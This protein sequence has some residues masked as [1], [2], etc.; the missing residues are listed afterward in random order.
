MNIFIPDSFSTFNQVIVEVAEFLLG[1]PHSKNTSVEKVVNDVKSIFSTVASDTELAY[2]RRQLDIATERG[3][4]RLIGMRSM[5]L[6]IQGGEEEEDGIKCSVP[7]ESALASLPR[8]LKPLSRPSGAGD[9]A[10]ALSLTGCANGVQHCIFS[11]M[12][13]IF[14]VLDAILDKDAVREQSTSLMYCILA[15][16]FTGV[17]KSNK[18][19]STAIS[20]LRSILSRHTWAKRDFVD[21]DISAADRLVNMAH[22]QDKLRLLKVSSSMLLS[23]S[24]QCNTLEARSSMLDLLLDEITRMCSTL[25]EEEKS[26]FKKKGVETLNSDAELLKTTTANA[27][28]R[29]KRSVKDIM[30]MDCMEYLST[31]GSVFSKSTAPPREQHE[32]YISSLLDAIQAIVGMAE[33][34]D[35]VSKRSH[36]MLSLLG[37]SDQ[38]SGDSSDFLCL[39][40]KFQ[41]RMMRLL[42]PVLLSMDANAI[43]ARKVLVMCQAIWTEHINMNL[44]ESAVALL[45]YLFTFSSDWRASINECLQSGATSASEDPTIFRGVLAYFGGLPQTLADDAFVVIEGE[46]SSSSSSG[47][48]NKLRGGSPSGLPTGAVST[49]NPVED[50]ISGLSRHDALSGVVSGIDTRTGSCDVMVLGDRSSVQIGPRVD[51]SREQH[52]KVTIRA[53]RVGAGNLSAVNELPLTM[54][55]VC[56]LGVV[57]P[58]LNTMKL[59]TSCIKEDAR[60]ELVDDVELKV[61]DLSVTDLMTCGMGLR[62]VS[63]AISDPRNLAR[64]LTEEEASTPYFANAL[65]LG[66]AGLRCCDGLD[67]LS[68]FEA[69]LW[70]VISTRK[71]VKTRLVNLSSAS[72]SELELFAGNE[73]D[74]R[75]QEDAREITAPKKILKASSRAKPSSILMGRALRLREAS[76][77]ANRE[78]DETDE[79]TSAAGRSSSGRGERLGAAAAHLREAAL[80]QMA[81]LGLPRQWAELALDRVGG[82]N[83]EQAVHFCLERSS[84]MESLVAEEAERSSSSSSSLSRRS[85]TFGVSRMASANLLRQLTEM[86]FPRV[87]VVQNSDVND[88]YPSS[89]T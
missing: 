8:M 41:R 36:R 43:V 71:E 70:H 77:T 53:M 68:S 49:P 1:F 30:S 45:R 7:I 13:C 25:R 61:M 50:V 80:I 47:T 87:S 86:G 78:Q 21:E 56:G 65:L 81:E 32:I 62:A 18:T 72:E 24:V 17:E 10:Q 16:H 51:A 64:Y 74:A 28:G 37:L 20:S 34:A 63:T 82:T 6:L 11:S 2:L 89:P 19:I 66:S 60:A 44:G 75:S 15:C 5:Q 73:E 39:P 12:N 35:P 3:V 9:S 88:D 79:S 31:H 40:L 76:S 42:R 55:G 59:V 48:P 27:Q 67:S 26:I 69:R 52:D 22:H 58:L 57:S 14:G 23:L 4:M 85:G 54:D 38:D 83:I 46:A 84:E 33:F 29:P